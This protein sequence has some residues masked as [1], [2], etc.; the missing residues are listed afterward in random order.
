MPN[1]FQYI[2][3]V[4]SL[5]NKCLVVWV[6]IQQQMEIVKIRSSDPQKRTP[7]N[8]SYHGLIIQLL[9]RSKELSSYPDD[10]PRKK[11]WTDRLIQH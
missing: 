5:C 1:Y 11:I 2:V 4:L 6:K 9:F 8:Q 10:K 7:N 3:I